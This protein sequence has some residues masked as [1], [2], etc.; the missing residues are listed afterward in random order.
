MVKGFLEQ[1]GELCK[2]NDFWFGD[3][4]QETPI[5]LA[6]SQTKIWFEKSDDNDE[7]IRKNFAKIHVQFAANPPTENL[8]FDNCL[9]LIILFDQFSRNMYR[10][11]AKMFAFDRI[12]LGLTKEFI[13]QN[14][15]LDFDLFRALF[16]CMPLMYSENLEDQNTM[17]G[18]SKKFVEECKK[19]NSLH[20]GYFEN[21]LSFALRH[22]EIIENFGRFPHRNQI[23]GRISTKEEAEFLK[24][25]NSSF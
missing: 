20:L 15:V 5:E 23:L 13:S 14:N 2:I 16:V 9:A 21:S 17:V 8:G 19:Q 4:T 6:Q 1:E 24:T 22:L 3:L 12:A 7:F 25:P 10:G 11:I 18:F